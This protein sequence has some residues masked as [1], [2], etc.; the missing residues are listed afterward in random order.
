[1][2]IAGNAN[3]ADRELSKTIIG[4]GEQLLGAWRLSDEALKAIKEDSPHSCDPANGK[5]DPCAACMCLL[6]PCWPCVIK[7]IL[8]ARNFDPSRTWGSQLYLLTDRALYVHVDDRFNALG[9]DEWLGAILDSRLYP[10]SVSVP[11]AQI[12]NPN[13]PLDQLQV[14]FTDEDGD[15]IGEKACHTGMLSRLVLPKPAEADL[16]PRKAVS[17]KLGGRG[18]DIA[19]KPLS[20]MHCAVPAAPLPQDWQTHLSAQTPDAWPGWDRTQYLAGRYG[21]SAAITGGG[22]SRAHPQ[23]PFYSRPHFLMW[24][25]FE[26]SQFDEA[27]QL[28]S[29]TAAGAGAVAPGNQ[30]MG[31]T[32][33]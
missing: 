16:M 19:P 6:P 24:L 15:A 25:W 31:R 30:E 7:G 5:I 4:E 14:P 20:A 10:R 18:F 22:R 11:L 23:F 12:G 32:E 1:M 2:A 28:I 33:A 29:S 17:T 27:L 13:C 21:S 26:H 8:Q 3:T 9:N